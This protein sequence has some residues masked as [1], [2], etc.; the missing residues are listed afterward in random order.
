MVAAPGSRR[1]ALRLL[2]GGALGALL[3]RIG[4]EGVE[5]ACL[6]VPKPCAAT[7]NCCQGATC[8]GSGRCVKNGRP[9]GKCRC[10]CPS[11]LTECGGRCVDTQTDEGNCGGCG[12]AGSAFKCDSGETCQNGACSG[13]GCGNPCQ[14][15]QCG[16]F[17]D[18]CGTT[19]DCGTCSGGNHC[20]E[21]T[22]TCPPG[23]GACGFDGVCQDFLSDMNNCGGCGAS[24]PQ[25]RCDPDFAPVGGS[26]VCDNGACAVTCPDG[27]EHCSGTCCGAGDLCLSSGAFNGFQ[28]RPRLICPAEADNCTEL[29]RGS[30]FACD[31]VSGCHCSL[32]IEGDSRCGGAVVSRGGA[33]IS[34]AACA[35]THGPGAFCSRTVA[36]CNGS[37]NGESECVLPCV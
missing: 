8:V 29:G 17:P 12:A 10:T 35:S 36:A 13:G 31:S 5:A 15:R 2:G 16:E 33:C 6:K 30:S 14:G 28:C 4:V 11:N 22:C 34:S 7:K 26:M 21:S 27:R 18:S 3:G 1:A 37:C 24:D 25:Y 23:T 20:V 32:S 9:T 19:I